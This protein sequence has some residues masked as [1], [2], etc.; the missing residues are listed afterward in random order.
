[1]VHKFHNK[2]LQLFTFIFLATFTFV[3]YSYFSIQKIF[4]SLTFGTLSLLFRIC[5]VQILILWSIYSIALFPESQ[6]VRMHK[7][8]TTFYATLSVEE[9]AIL[10]L[11]SGQ[12]QKAGSSREKVAGGSSPDTD[13]FIALGNCLTCCDTMRHYLFTM[14]HYPKMFCLKCRK[15]KYYVIVN[16][17]SVIDWW[18]VGV[19]WGLLHAQRIWGSFQWIFRFVYAY[20]FFKCIYDKVTSYSHNS[21]FF[22]C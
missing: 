3:F 12:V 6:I 4:T 18:L 14:V 2:C 8:I 19:G 5:S 15:M 16:G 21:F 13:V 1:M 9:N 17:L 20:N 11:L 7:S 10:R 22:N